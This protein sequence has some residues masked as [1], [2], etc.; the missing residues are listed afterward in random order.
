MLGGF[1]MLRR[2]MLEELG[3]F[4]EGFRLYGED[5]DLA[6]ARR[7][8]AGSAGTSRRRS[9]QH[10]HK[11]VTDRRWL[12]RRTLWHWARD[13]PLRAQAPRAAARALAGASR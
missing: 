12:T 5:I 1:L 4:D 2:A 8:P 6:T 13:R 3:G 7:G 11:A 9:S 10:E